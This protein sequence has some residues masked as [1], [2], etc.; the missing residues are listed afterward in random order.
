ME[1]EKKV[2]EAPAQETATEQE[3]VAEPKGMFDEA[4][5][6]LSAKEQRRNAIFHQDDKKITNN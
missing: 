6:A 2:T 3:A 5:T 4:F 1:E